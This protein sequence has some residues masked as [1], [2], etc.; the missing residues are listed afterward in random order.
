MV[1]H[2]MQ[3]NSKFLRFSLFTTFSIR[4]GWLRKNLA[5]ELKLENNLVI[6]RII[7]MELIQCQLQGSVF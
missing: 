4:E 1:S 2:Y 3:D 5:D 6:K 7:R